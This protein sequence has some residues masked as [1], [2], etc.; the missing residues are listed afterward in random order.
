MKKERTLLFLGIWVAILPN[1]GF[2]ELWRKILFLLSGL[3]L[4][5]ISYIM[6]RRKR[7]EN[8]KRSHKTQNNVMNAFSESAPQEFE[9][10]EEQPLDNEY[11]YESYSQ[12]VDEQ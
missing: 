7:Y 12:E 4:M 10:N 1:L 2:P 5:F 8:I 6:Y 11:A 3:F 9:K